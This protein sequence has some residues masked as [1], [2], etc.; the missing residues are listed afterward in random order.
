M[1][2]KCWKCK[3]VNEAQHDG[4]CK[5]KVC[6]NWYAPMK[7]EKPVQRFLDDEEMGE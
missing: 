2:A 7:E 1:K 6:D 3:T 4:Y 5:C